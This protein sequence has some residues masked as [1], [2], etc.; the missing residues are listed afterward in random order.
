VIIINQTNV[1]PARRRSTMRAKTDAITIIADCKRRDDGRARP[2]ASTFSPR[3]ASIGRNY[4]FAD[5]EFD[6]PRGFIDDGRTPSQR[7]QSVDRARQQS[8]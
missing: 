8:L 1:R 6:H 4:P 2:S 7:D 3:G 5:R